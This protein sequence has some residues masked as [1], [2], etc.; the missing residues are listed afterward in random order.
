MA[1]PA[2][3][4]G[5]VEHH[6]RVSSTCLITHEHNRYSVP[7]SFANRPVSLRV[8]AERLVIVAEARVIATHERGVEVQWATEDEHGIDADLEKV[9]KSSN[10]SQS[11]KASKNAAKLL[12]TAVNILFFDTRVLEL[13]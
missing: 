7:A 6:K 10:A 9:L 8:Y 11:K 3:F 2:A 13:P 12:I 1:M 4:D 5:F